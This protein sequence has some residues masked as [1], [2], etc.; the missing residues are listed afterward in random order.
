MEVYQRMI[1][2]LHY[3][4][5]FAKDPT[6]EVLPNK[7]QILKDIDF[8]RA[9]PNDGSGYIL[10]QMIIILAHRRLRE[11]ELPPLQRKIVVHTFLNTEQHSLSELAATFLQKNGRLAKVFIRDFLV[12]KYTPAASLF[13]QWFRPKLRYLHDYGIFSMREIMRAPYAAYEL[14]NLLFPANVT[15]YEEPEVVM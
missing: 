9:L 12:L 7:E 13:T 2:N 4:D 3:A 15:E 8:L 14:R 6:K 10:S 5:W 11:W 1:R